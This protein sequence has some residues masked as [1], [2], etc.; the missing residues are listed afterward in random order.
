MKGT[1]KWYNARKGYGFITPEDKSDDV[2]VHAT[3]LKDC[4][5]KKLYTGSEVTFEVDQDDK[6]KRAK[7]IKV[8]K[9]IKPPKDEKKDTKKKEK[10]IEKKDTKK[11]EKKIEKKDTKKKE[12]KT[13]KKDSK[14]EK[15]KPKKKIQKKKESSKK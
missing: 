10:K 5:L 13:E 7:S 8:T 15:E 12:K 1:I 4:G 9:E 3:S 6:G 2:F 14:Q 11:K